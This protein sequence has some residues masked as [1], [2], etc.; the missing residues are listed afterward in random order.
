MVNDKLLTTSENEIADRARN[1]GVRSRII[2]CTL[3]FV[4]CNLFLTGCGGIGGNSAAFIVAGSTSVQPYV[5]ILVEEYAILYPNK[6]IDVQGGGSSAGI[7]AVESHTA[8]IG[9]SSRNLKDTEEYLWS[10]EITKDGLAIIVNPENIVKSL[11]LEEIRGIYAADYV[12]WNQL[13]GP[14][15]RIH[16]ITREEG[17]GTRSAF[18]ELVMDEQR[19]TPRAIVQDS[20]GAVRQLVADDP[21]SIGFISLGLVDTG[22]RPVQ[23]LRIN[24]IAATRN[25]VLNGDYLLFRSFLF[26]SLEKPTGDVMQFI[27]F[28]RSPAG[29][30][31]MS[32]EGLIPEFG[33]HDD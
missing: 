19:I 4:I 6:F 16:I 32:D 2:I 11:T 18:E 29:Q 14:D 12:N 21:Y 25:N 15:A 17:S 31:I 33:I 1:N 23:A 7:Q 5:E 9:M 26:V 30:K 3:L 10:I 24:D 22:E 28:I 20:N 8:E 27:D 13:G